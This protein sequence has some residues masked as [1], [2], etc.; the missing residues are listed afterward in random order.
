ML[1]NISFYSKSADNNDEDHVNIYASEEAFSSSE[2]NTPEIEPVCTTQIVQKKS[3]KSR[4]GVRADII[5]TEIE[6]TRF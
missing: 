6:S 1:H 3:V 5:D 2:N 4:L